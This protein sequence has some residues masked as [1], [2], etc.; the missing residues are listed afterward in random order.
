[1]KKY[2]FSAKHIIDVRVSKKEDLNTVS[3]PC[4]DGDHFI[5][6]ESE[7]IGLALRNNFN[8]TSPFIPDNYKQGMQLCKN[9]SIG[10]M[11]Q[12][13]IKST[14]LFSTNMWKKDYFFLPPCKYFSYNYHTT[15]VFKGYLQ[16]NFFCKF[17][18]VFIF[19]LILG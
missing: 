10:K 12:N 15:N 16:L 3:T 13:F 1:M 18:L 17:F 4:Y 6:A 14:G 5:Q 9:A 7:K 2:Y 11:A 19:Q 8:C